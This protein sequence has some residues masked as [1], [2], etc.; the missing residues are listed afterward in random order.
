MKIQVLIKKVGA[1]RTGTSST[2][3]KPWAVRN[4]L[5]GFE[6]ETGNSYLYASVDSDVWNR[7]G[8]VEGTVATVNLRFRTKAFV[9]GFVANE[10][11][12]VEPENA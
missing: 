3:G 2:T 6:D 9:N 4:I 8:L 10:I 12:I 11:R 1:E 7:L 5:L